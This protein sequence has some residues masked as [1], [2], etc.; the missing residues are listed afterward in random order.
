MKK[1]ILE[2]GYLTKALTNAKGDILG[3]TKDFHVN[4][5]LDSGTYYWSDVYVYGNS[6]TI[7]RKG[8]LLVNSTPEDLFKLHEQSKINLS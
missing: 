8:S 5:N 1:Q 7:I 2:G 3:I 4:F 6:Y